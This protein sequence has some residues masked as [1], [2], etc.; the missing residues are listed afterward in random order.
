MFCFYLSIFVEIDL[1]Q[2]VVEFYFIE[3]ERNW[4]NKMQYEW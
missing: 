2:I 1:D 3:T 4:M